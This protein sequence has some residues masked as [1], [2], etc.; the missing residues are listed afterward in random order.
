MINNH[1]PG[2]PAIINIYEQKKMMNGNVTSKLEMLRN[3]NK[4][5]HFKGK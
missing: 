2:A 4:S 3:L 1:L 5:L